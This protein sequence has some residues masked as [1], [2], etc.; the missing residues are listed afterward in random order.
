ML[1][2]TSGGRAGILPWEILKSLKCH[3][4]YTLG[5]FYK[6]SKGCKFQFQNCLFDVL[7]SYTLWKWA[8]ILCNATSIYLVKNCWKSFFVL[9]FSSQN[10]KFMIWQVLFVCGL[11]IIV[12]IK[13]HLKQMDIVEMDISMTISTI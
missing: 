12:D 10:Q 5:R 13:T 8:W 11:C 4:L 1:I 3:F 9:P 6:N 7:E 2:F